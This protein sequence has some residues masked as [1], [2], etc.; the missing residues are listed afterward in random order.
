N[1]VSQ[2]SE[3]SCV[4]WDSCPLYE[5][6]N[7]FTPNGDQYNDTFIPLNYPS[8]N[9]KANVERIELV[10]FTRWGNTVFQTNDPLINWDGKNQ[11]TGIDCAD[12]TYFYK[13]KVFFQSLD[14]E[15]EHQLQGS[16]TIIR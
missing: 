4:D 14:G 6:P 11:T 1:N 16:I 2:A 5:L 3:I 10:I 12:G 13:C 7:V 8:T 15:I 9:P